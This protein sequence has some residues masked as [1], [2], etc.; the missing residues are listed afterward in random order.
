[1]CVTT[2]EFLFALHF[3]WSVLLLENRILVS[4]RLHLPD[5]VPSHSYQ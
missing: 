5:I 4:Y 2:S 1:M 3:C